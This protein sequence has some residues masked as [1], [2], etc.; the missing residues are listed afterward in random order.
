MCR[1]RSEE[2]LGKRQPLAMGL[3]ILGFEHVAGRCV[4]KSGLASVP[5]NDGPCQ[6]DLVR[7][8][9]VGAKI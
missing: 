1:I 9:L 6:K 4:E 5:T 7:A 8:L 3:T 2:K